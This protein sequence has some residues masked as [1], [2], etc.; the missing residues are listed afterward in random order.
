MIG[1]SDS[2]KDGGFIASNW[3]LYKA[4]V[5]LTVLGKHLGVPIAFFHGRGGSVSRGRR[6]DPSRHRG[7]AAG[8]DQR[9]LPHH[10]AGRGRLVQICQP[11]H[12][13]LSDGAAGGLGL[14]ARP[15]L[16][17]QRQRLAGRTRRRAGGASAAPLGPPMSTCSR[18]TASSTTSRPP[19]RWTRSRCSI[20]LAPARRFGAKAL[21]DL[22]AIPWVFAWSQN[23]HVITGWYGVGLG[24]EELHRRSRRTGRSA[25]AAALQGCP[26][27][28]SS[29]PRPDEVE[30]TL[31][32]VD[33][34]IAP[35]TMPAS[36]RTRAS[37]PASSA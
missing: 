1:Y 27:F 19:A 29:S 15:A 34:E 30:K 24:D 33:L 18:P 6:A 26:V 2:N 12:G 22:R 32:M 7:P 35:A 25:A 10:R 16:G 14:R 20:S 8:L 17:R 5:R 37:G 28:R 4:Q 11:R 3:E 31:M 13:L 9:T 36:C 21:S 23:R